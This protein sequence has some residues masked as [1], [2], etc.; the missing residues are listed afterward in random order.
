MKFVL[1]HKP[2]YT[3]NNGLAT[4][5][6]ALDS[7]GKESSDAAPAGELF[8]ATLNAIDRV[9]RLSPVL[10]NSTIRVTT[11]GKKI[12]VKVFVIINISGYKA[13]GHGSSNDIV[14]AIAIAY[15]E[16]INRALEVKEVKRNV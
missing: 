1:V 11:K 7:G 8:K 4:V 16:A 5:T 14:E 9:T 10:L 12:E 3:V 15:L 2:S 6:V 13:E